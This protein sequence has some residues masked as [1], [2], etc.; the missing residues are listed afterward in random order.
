MSVRRKGREA[1]TQ[2]LCGLDAQEWPVERDIST[3]WAIRPTDTQAQRFAASLIEGVLKHREKLDA[4]IAELA[5][6][7]QLH[8]LALVDRNILRIALYEIQDCP[9]VPVPVVIN[10]AIEI[11]KKFGTEESSKFVN[12]ILDRAASQPNTSWEPV[13]TS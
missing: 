4:R 9:D 2:Y 6:N 10:E 5:V 1:A 3:F 8:R 13:S 12:G 11:A 7:Y